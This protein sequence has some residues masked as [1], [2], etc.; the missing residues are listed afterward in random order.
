MDSRGLISH[1]QGRAFAEKAPP[2]EKGG[3]GTLFPAT[4]RIRGDR[5][6]PKDKIQETDDR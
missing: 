2:H 1:L 4:V 6:I 3:G 5:P